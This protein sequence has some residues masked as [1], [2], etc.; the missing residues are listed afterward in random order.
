MRAEVQVTHDRGKDIPLPIAVLLGERLLL[1]DKGSPSKL[2]LCSGVLQLVPALRRS[3]T[4]EVGHTIGRT[5]AVSYRKN[6]QKG[7]AFQVLQFGFQRQ[8][9]DAKKA[10]VA[11]YL[12][13]L[14]ETWQEIKATLGDKAE[15]ECFFFSWQD[16][17]FAPLGYA[18]VL[19][20]LHALLKE[21]GLSAAKA[22]SFTLNS[23]KSVFP[24]YPCY[25]S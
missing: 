10:W 12:W 4:C 16:K 8:L 19:M 24:S 25:R 7:H 15:P 6:L 20:S 18:Q 14:G 13:L 17:E 2:L 21:W 5:R 22:S 9:H 1:V 23:V 3:S 11:K